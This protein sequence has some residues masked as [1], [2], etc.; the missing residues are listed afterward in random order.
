M[1]DKAIITSVSN[2]FFP[3]LVNLLGSIKANY[4]KHPKIYIYDL[5]LFWTFRKELE[6]IENVKV[7]DMPRFVSFWRSCYT[8]KTYILAHP[9]ADLNFY[10]DAGCQV[11]KP[12]DKI[13]EKIEQYDYF[14]IQQGIKLEKIVPLDFWNKFGLD[15]KFMNYEAI[16]AGEI[17]FKAGTAFSEILNQVF[18]W[19]KQGLALGFSLKDQWRNKNHD[20]NN[21]IRDCEIFRHDMTLLNIAVRKSLGEN[22]IIQE[23]G[24]Y[25]GGKDAH[26]DQLI[27]NLR[28]NYKKLDYLNYSYLHSQFL[29]LAWANRFIVNVML[30]LKNINL[31]FKKYFKLLT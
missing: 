14:L 5:G 29:F 10:M 2:K 15:K 21:I 12:L 18:D 23:G 16:H 22:F 30:L 4:P 9:L 20:K 13:F 8:W 31:Y 11:L 17:G 24:I 26:P 7:L 1:E 19:G 27:W 6:Q 3:S 25:A 28:L